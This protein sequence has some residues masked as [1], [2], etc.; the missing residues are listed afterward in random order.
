MKTLHYLYFSVL[1][2]TLGLYSCTKQGGYPLPKPSTQKAT[3]HLAIQSPRQATLRGI[4]SETPD[5][6]L[7]PHQLRLVFYSEGAT[8]LV[9]E[10][11]EITVTPSTNLQDLPVALPEGSYQLVVIANPT[12]TLREPSASCSMLCS[13][14]SLSSPS[15][16]SMQG[17]P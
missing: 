2:L 10:I 12:T 8:P 13:T 1:L 14:P 6:L 15:R 17:I 7:T 4:T 5:P 11:R 16:C 9:K 3:L